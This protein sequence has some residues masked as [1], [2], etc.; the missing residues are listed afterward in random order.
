MK[1]KS[2][3]M[4]TSHIIDTGEEYYRRWGPNSW[5]ELMGESWEPVYYDKEETLEKLFQEYIR[6]NRKLQKIKRQ[7]EALRKMI[8][9]EEELGLNW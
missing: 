6:E 8:E 9:N 5:Q 1:I 2:V 4:E 7:Q 3:E